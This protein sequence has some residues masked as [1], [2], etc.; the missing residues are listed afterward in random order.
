[1]TRPC[2]VLTASDGREGLELFRQHHPQITLL[3][4]R[5]PE[6]GGIEV[7]KQIRAVDPRAAV[8]VLTGA[9]TESRE[10]QARELGVTDF[11]SKG[12]S[13]D[14][15]VRAMDHVIQQPPKASSLPPLFANAPAGSTETASIL[16]VDDELM[17][18]DLLAK[19][20]HCGAARVVRSHA[21]QRDGPCRSCN[22]VRPRHPVRGCTPG[23]RG[24][25]ARRSG[26]WRKR[27]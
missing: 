23:P 1:M 21:I 24:L 22:P 10:C 3:D 26:R 5:M 15:L 13:M 4:L 11:L 6:M 14:A 16:V 25:G 8:M 12:L 7:L 17:I 18:R 19:L 9:G 2:E 27:S 20:G